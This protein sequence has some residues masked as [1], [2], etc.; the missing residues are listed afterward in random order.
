MDRSGQGVLASTAQAGSA[1]VESSKVRAVFA[2]LERVLVRGMVRLAGAGRWRGAMAA[3]LTVLAAGC[4]TEPPKLA[5]TPTFEPVYPI[6]A[7]P[8]S[9][10]TGGIYKG[11]QSDNWFGRGRS[12][13]VG[14]VITVLLNESTQA[15][16]QQSR[17]VSRESSNDVIPSGLSATLGA[18]S[19]RLAGL[20][21][22]GA[23]ISSDG[24]GTAGQRASLTGS[25]AATVV[26]VLANGN[27]VIRG[28][29]Q[30]ALAE[31]TEI[32]QVSGVIRPEDISANN[33]VQSRRLANAQFTYRGTGELDEASRAGWGTRWAL[34]FWPF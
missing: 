30:L 16:R 9:H 5:H 19:A 22:N 14:D 1:G 23:A 28:E 27:L 18:Q 29:K 8:V 33:V 13:Q 11:R 10:A 3:G 12:Y 31:G 2:A 24:Q 32:I 20:N 25:V 6:P 21:L 4:A 15:A 34:K 7:D 17:S 26:Q